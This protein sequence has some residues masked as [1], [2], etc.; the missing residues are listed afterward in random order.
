MR[1][2]ISFA[3]VSAPIRLPARFPRT[4]MR[5][6]NFQE[7]LSVA[8]GGLGNSAGI[9]YPIYDPTSLASC[10]AH[11]TNGPCRYQYGYGPGGTN[12]ANGNPVKTGAPIN[13]IPASQLSPI[14]QYMQKFLPDPTITTTGTIQN[15]YLGGSPV[16]SITGSTPAGS[17]TT[18]PLG[19]RFRLPL[20]VATAM[21]CRT[22]ALRTRR[23]LCLTMLQPSRRLPATGPNLSTPLRSLR[24]WST[25]SSSAS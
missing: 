6:G 17:T 2:T 9:N 23:C 22:P 3:R 25:S 7:L 4:L 8:N 14:T 20:L 16:A 19:R 11:S 10:T 12:G 24:T 13:V 18:S 1:P 15:N 21:P 5:Q